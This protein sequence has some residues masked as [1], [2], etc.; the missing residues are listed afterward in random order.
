MLHAVVGLGEPVGRDGRIGASPLSD[1]LGDGTAQLHAAQGFGDLPVDLFSGVCRNSG[2]VTGHCADRAAHECEHDRCKRDGGAPIG[3][4]SAGEAL[5]DALC[6]SG[7]R[8]TGAPDDRPFQ[9]SLRE[10]EEV[11]GRCGGVRGYRDLA[12]A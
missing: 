8:T 9:P 1:S 3:T 6:K 7:E 11:A 4:A 2:L 5:G 10:G 12:Q